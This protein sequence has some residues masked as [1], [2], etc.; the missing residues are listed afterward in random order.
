[1]LRSGGNIAKEKWGGA[2]HRDQTGFKRNSRD[3][4]TTLATF[5]L[6]F[7]IWNDF[8]FLITCQDSKQ[9]VL[10][11]PRVCVCVRVYVCCSDKNMFLET[12]SPAGPKRLWVH[13]QV[14]VAR[15][16]PA[17]KHHNCAGFS[18]DTLCSWDQ[19]EGQVRRWVW[20]DPWVLGQNVN[21]LTDVAVG[22]MSSQD[23]LTHFTARHGSWVWSTVCV[24]T[25]F[26]NIFH[27][28]SFL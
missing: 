28:N 20:S 8:L 5:K 16:L 21:V 27:W 23:G 19:N 7:V 12:P 26:L 15:F 1:M 4:F 9:L 6:W 11:S 14:S 2:R 3:R 25:C 17:Q 18:Q 13:C 10:F 22:L 24:T